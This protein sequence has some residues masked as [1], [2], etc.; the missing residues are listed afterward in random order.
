MRLKF[1]FVFSTAA[2]VATNYHPEQSA[3]ISAFAFMATAAALLPAFR[4]E[5]AGRRHF[6][7]VTTTSVFVVSCIAVAVGRWN[8]LYAAWYVVLLVLLA[9]SAG[10]P[11]VHVRSQPRPSAAIRKAVDALCFAVLFAVAISSYMFFTTGLGI[12]NPNAAAALCGMLFLIAMI[13]RRTVELSGGSTVRSTVSVTLFASAACCALQL[14]R[15]IVFWVAAAYLLRL[16]L[17]GI[18]APIRTLLLKQM[19]ILIL[20]APVLVVGI[21]EN[22]DVDAVSDLI[23]GLP[24]FLRLKEGGLDSDVLRFI[25]YPVVLASQIG[26]SK[27]LLFGLGFGLRPYLESLEPGEDLHNAYLVIISDGGA[28]LLLLVLLLIVYRRNQSSTLMSLRMII[29][30]SASVFSGILVGLA[31]FTLTVTAFF[32]AVS[33]IESMARP[34]RSTCREVRRLPRVANLRLTR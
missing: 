23:L 4:L 21:S 2:A 34:R 18:R 10:C 28:V 29:F 31:P 24:S 1:G 25:H 14:S 8:L 3:L 13:D 16:I 19:G 30:A 20:V 7:I 17:H 32:V 26:P 22:I 12:L 27:D 9:I 15:S 6:M 5:Q 33:N 11:A